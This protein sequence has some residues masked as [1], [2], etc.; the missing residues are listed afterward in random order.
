M[1]GRED[2][3]GRHPSDAAPL[4]LAEP[5]VGGVLDEAVHPLD[6]VPQPG[7]DLL[8]CRAPVDEGLS[9]A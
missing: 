2:A 3:L 1:D 8:V 6:G 7:V 9:L 4:A 5:L